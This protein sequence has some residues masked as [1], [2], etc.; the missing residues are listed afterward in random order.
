MRKLAKRLGALLL[1]T[2]MLL[3]ATLSAGA[4]EDDVVM[5]TAGSKYDPD[6]V[7]VGNLSSK[8]KVTAYQLVQYDENNYNDY[9]VEENFEKF[10]RA[11][12][13]VDTDVSNFLG[14][15]S[16]ADMN[17][18]LEEFATA[19][20]T[21]DSGYNLPDEYV[22]GVANGEKSAD[23]KLKP[24]Y[25][26]LLVTS[27]V[28]NSKVYKP[29]SVFVEVDGK[30]VNVYGGGNKLTAVSTNDGDIYTFNVKSA[31]GP[32]L[33]KKTNATSET[34]ETAT[35]K[36]TAA[37]AVGETVRFRVQIDIP[38]YTNIQKLNMKVNDT[39]TNMEYVEDSAKIYTTEPQLNVEGGKVS[40][41]GTVKEGYTP[42]VTKGEYTVKNHTGTQDL[43]FTLDHRQ[44]VNDVKTGGTVWLYY[45]AVVKK[46]S[47]AEKE[48]TGSNTASLTYANAATPDTSTTT[49]P[50]TTT[51]VNYY[52][53]LVKYKDAEQTLADATFS[54]YETEAD[55]EKNNAIKF[56]E[57]KDAD[58]TV[59]YRPLENNESEDGLTIVTKLEAE[60][61]IRGLDANTY[62][63]KE[64]DTPS[65]YYAPKGI[66]EI[67][68]TSKME[69]N[70]EHSG[71][72]EGST[73]EIT[74][75]NDADKNLILER[76]GVDNKIGHQFD[77]ALLN[78]TTPSLPTTGGMGTMLF[79]IGGVAL[80]ALAAYVFFFRKRGE[81]K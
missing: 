22:S 38:G 45:E 9:I 10:V 81:A 7:R 43:T 39:L 70:G 1:A 23:L 47:V 11:K 56:V 13:S 71:A 62:C 55:A 16:S 31:D 53:S 67:K 78:S 61:L 3:G 28:Q 74:A 6:T 27:T 51:T 64:I 26:L 35:W 49:D 14:N 4:L 15:L 79:T 19:C 66:F 54:L 24:G 33:D 8:D 17:T 69:K 75:K 2:L 42:E 63:L 73:T 80:M 37:A 41:T 57:M 59:Y 25:Y 52:L 40:V 65:G 46:E 77:I 34:S 60:F 5:G 20:K 30:G 12:R 72:L 48:H 76:S 36:N 18:L 29:M 44:L 68:L 58:G 32:T 50:S 21:V